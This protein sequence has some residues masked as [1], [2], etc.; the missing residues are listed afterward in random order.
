MLKLFTLWN[1]RLDLTHDKAVELWTR[2]HAPRVVASH[3]AHLL[4]YAC[5]V[6]VPADY[7]GWAPDEAP[8]WDGVAEGW[9]DVDDP[10]ELAGL[11]AA[12]A[13]ELR[14]SERGFTGTLQHVVTDQQVHLDKGHA[15]RGIKMLF[16]LTRRTDMTPDQAVRYWRERHVPLVRDTLGDSLVRYTTNVGLAAGFRGWSPQEAP[17]YDGIAEL[18]VD[19]SA[20]AQQEFIAANKSVLF[21]DERAFMGTYRAVFAREILISGRDDEFLPIGWE[22]PGAFSPPVCRSPVGVRSHPRSPGLA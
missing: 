21:P 1:R 13:A 10:A 5:N 6:G 16:M 3:G 2:G 20:T 8:A 22:R 7:S 17:A 4:R 14:A 12:T 9:Y 19:H 15:H 11:V 18:A